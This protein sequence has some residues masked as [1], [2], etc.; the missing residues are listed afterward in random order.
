MLIEPGTPEWQSARLG[1]FTA[2]EIHKLMGER[3]GIKTATAQSYILEKVAEQMTGR[4][5]SSVGS[6]ATDWGH[7]HEPDAREY[8]EI[9]FKCEVEKQDP[10]PAWFTDHAGCTP[11]GIVTPI[12]HMSKG[13]E[14]KC[15]YNSANH[16]KHMQIKDNM[17]FKAIAKEYYW[18]VQMCM[19]ITKLSKWDF[20]SYD[21]RFTGKLRM[22]VCEIKQHVQDMERLRETILQAVEMKLEIINKLKT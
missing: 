2:S 4:T 18:Q 13:V 9:A 12:N 14:I 10:I 8:Y 19:L 7:E 20:V 6:V 11:D 1:K 21:P 17:S 15:P 5:I 3:G 16:L 22:Y